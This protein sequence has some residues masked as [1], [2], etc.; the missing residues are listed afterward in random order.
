MKREVRE[1][2]L[3]TGGVVRVEERPT[4][5]L[6]GLG[7]D[8]DQAL[9]DALF[10]TTEEAREVYDAISSITYHVEQKRREA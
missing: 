9:T 2:V 6:L 3:E 8:M 1:V 5:M 10:L 7:Q 4:G